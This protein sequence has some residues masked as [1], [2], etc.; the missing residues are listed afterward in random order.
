MDQIVKSGNCPRTEM[1]A[2]DPT[3]FRCLWSDRI[4][5]RV[6]LLLLLLLLLLHPVLCQ[7]W[8]QVTRDVML[9]V[10]SATEALGKHIQGRSRKLFADKWDLVHG[11]C[12]INWWVLLV[13]RAQYHG[14]FHLYAPLAKWMPLQGAKAFGHAKVPSAVKQM[15][16]AQWGEWQWTADGEKITTKIETRGMHDTLP[17]PYSPQHQG[18]TWNDETL[19]V[20]FFFSSTV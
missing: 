7:T 11:L 13:E 12:G 1:I 18:M 9:M 17:V 16:T 8:Q 10:G 20:F 15:A 14:G 3:E 5:I 2:D 19:S 4:Q 6:P